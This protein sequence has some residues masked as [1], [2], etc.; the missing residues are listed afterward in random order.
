MKNEQDSQKAAKKIIGLAIAKGWTTDQTL[1]E[2]HEQH[3]DMKVISPELKDGLDGPAVK[4]VER[5]RV[6]VTQRKAA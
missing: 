5:L 4:L 6:H 2:M 3:V 1:D